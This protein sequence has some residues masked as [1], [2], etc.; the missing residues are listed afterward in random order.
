MTY[1]VMIYFIFRL[2]HI[3]MTYYVIIIIIKIYRSMIFSNMAVMGFHTLQHDEQLKIAVR[4][5]V[6]LR[7]L[8]DV[9]TSHVAAAFNVNLA[10][11]TDIVSVVRGASEAMVL[12][13]IMKQICKIAEIL[14]TETCWNVKVIWSVTLSIW[15]TR[16]QSVFLIIRSDSVIFLCITAMLLWNDCIV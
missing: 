13:E 4:L 16:F 15:Q 7:W 3:V 12:P 2:Y 9:Y 14:F 11:T 10:E 6:Y 1:Y 5:T 8:M